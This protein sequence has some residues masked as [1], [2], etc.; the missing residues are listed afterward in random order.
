MAYDK[1]LMQR[2]IDTYGLYTYEDFAEYVTYEQFIGF[3][4]AY[5][6]VSVGKGMITYEELIESIF[7]YV[8]P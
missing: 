8:N 4:A 2:D 1:E 3:N 5:L 6:K 7:A